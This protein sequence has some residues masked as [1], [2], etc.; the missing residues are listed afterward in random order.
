MQIRGYAGT[1]VGRQRDHNEDNHLVD[2][3][4]GLFVGA[5][6]VGGGNAGEVASAL[7]VEEA[8]LGGAELQPLLRHYK[9]RRD[10]ATRQQLIHRLPR[11]IE[12]ANDRIY[13]MAMQNPA[14]RGMATTVVML[15]TLG[16]D[17]FVCHAGDSRLYLFRDGT[18]FQ[19]TEDHSLVMRLYKK[20]LLSKEE[21][22]TH[23]R[24]NIILRSVGSQPN[25]EVDTLYLDVQPGDVFLLCSDG[26]S[27]LATE[28]E[29]TA[30]FHNYRGHDL[31]REAIA[32]AN[33]RGGKDNITVVVAEVGGAE[34]TD[35]PK[36]KHHLGMIQKV[37]FLQ[38]IFLFA[39]LTEQEC[40]KVNRIL[41]QR[42]YDTNDVV[43]REGEQGDEIYMVVRGHVGV[44][45]GG[46]ALTTIGP[47]G[48]FGEL[49]LLGQSLRSATV[50]AEEPCTLF[51]IRR[52]AFLEL[53]A[54][55]PVLG[56]KVL[57]A[58]LENLADRLRDLSDRLA[59]S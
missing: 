23:P 3:E 53:F 32:L 18:T 9:A 2:E 11:I 50:V 14:M 36:P 38:D 59:R 34:A 44:W 57:W 56:N 19:I 21:M 1:D 31:V 55:D 37:E 42:E 33:W 46:T 4:L 29:M 26:F 58:F 15:V 45:R 51:L 43:V 7:L 28:E 40:V 24:K 17:A 8:G 39:N 5:D 49:G 10:E 16:E 6:G 48:N 12:S 25:V 27:D 20:G 13:S 35:P 47:G 52:D 30:L 22:A 54:T 41:Y